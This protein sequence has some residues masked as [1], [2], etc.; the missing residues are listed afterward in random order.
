VAPRSLRSPRREPPHHP[1]PRQPHNL[2]VAPRAKRAF[3]AVFKGDVSEVTSSTP[4]AVEE[5]SAFSASWYADQ[6]ASSRKGIYVNRRIVAGERL[7]YLR[8]RLR[9]GNGSV[10]RQL[11]AHIGLLVSVV[12]M[13]GRPRT[14]SCHRTACTIPVRADYA[15]S[16]AEISL[17]SGTLGRKGSPA[18][19]SSSLT[20]EV[21]ER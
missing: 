6:C 19:A 15:P 12:K 21:A 2:A 1:R 13:V 16:W 14:G 8:L 3:H 20:R 9:S 18:H 7:L 17:L 11:L 4:R 5:A 10:H